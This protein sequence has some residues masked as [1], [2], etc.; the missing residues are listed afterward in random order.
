MTADAQNSWRGF[1]GRGNRSEH[2]EM[3]VRAFRCDG[4]EAVAIWGH[5]TMVLAVPPTA[6]GRAI[7]LRLQERQSEPTTQQRK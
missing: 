1:K 4:A 7:G 6:R 3:P 2:A 5:R